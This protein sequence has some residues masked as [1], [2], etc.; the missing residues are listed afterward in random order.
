MPAARAGILAFTQT[1]RTVTDCSRNS[2]RTQATG[3]A[4]AP[5]RITRGRLP[6]AAYLPPLAC[7]RHCDCRWTPGRHG[8]MR[9]RRA[10]HTLTQRLEGLANTVP[11]LSRTSV[12]WQLHMMGLLRPFESETE[13][14]SDAERSKLRAEQ[15]GRSGGGAGAAVTTLGQPQF[16]MEWLITTLASCPA[17]CPGRCCAAG[18]RLRSHICSPSLQIAE[19]LRQEAARHRR[20]WFM[21]DP[22][23]GPHPP[24]SSHCPVA[25]GVPAACCSNPIWVRP[26][27]LQA[28]PQRAIPPALLCLTGLL[29]RCWDL[30]AVVFIWI[31]I[32]LVPLYIA[33]YEQALLGWLSGP[34]PG[35]G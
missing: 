1:V 19:D 25:S 3:R 7:H 16:N 32:F 22:D 35:L 8:A 17:F 10:A 18:W 34:G 27:A 12:D 11:Y 30:I 24:A 5:Q 28:A 23:G 33:Y 13:S 31:L 4:T 2:V 14:A 29:R 6:A 9:V 26:A 15:V 20:P 21:L